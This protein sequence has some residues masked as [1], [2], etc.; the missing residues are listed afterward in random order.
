MSDNEK[1]TPEWVPAWLPSACSVEYVSDLLKL[2]LMVLI[3]VVVAHHLKNGRPGRATNIA[4]QG[5]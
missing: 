1:A 5:A 3:G 2:G 4:A